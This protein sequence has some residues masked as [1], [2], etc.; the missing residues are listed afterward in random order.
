MAPIP[1]RRP[2]AAEPPFG[3]Q[4][5]TEERCTLRDSTKQLVTSGEQ[6]VYKRERLFGPW[7]NP[8]GFASQRP[9][10]TLLGHHRSVEGEES[11]ADPLVVHGDK[12]FGPFSSVCLGRSFTEGENQTKQSNS[13]LIYIYMNIT[14]LLELNKRVGG[15]PVPRNVFHCF[16]SPRSI[17][18]QQA[19]AYYVVGLFDIL[20]QFDI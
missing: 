19:Y 9:R 10:A 14:T 7:S 4:H 13:L 5:R 11:K 6:G 12:L 16:L 2:P 3:S 15:V 20:C 8:W 1:Y 17:L 18:E